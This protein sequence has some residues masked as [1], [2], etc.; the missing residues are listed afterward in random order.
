MTN[1]LSQFQSKRILIVGDI[2][3]DH[4]LFGSTTRVSPEAPVPVVRLTSEK[5]CLGGAANVAYNCAQ[6]GSKVELLG[7][8]GA[9]DST[10]PSMLEAQNIQVHFAHPNHFKTIRKTRILSRHQQLLRLDEEPETAPLDVDTLFE[11]YQER[12]KHADAVI[13]SDYAKGVLHQPTRWIK[14]AQAEKVPVFVD[15]KHHDM[16][17]YRGA[18]AI[19]PNQN[20]L[21]NMLPTATDLNSTI[22]LSQQAMKTNQIENIV[23]TRG[24]AGMMLIQPNDSSLQLKAQTHDVFDVTGAGDTVIAMVALAYCCGLNWSDT[25]TLANLAAS[26]VINKMGTAAPDMNM[27]YHA[28][29]PQTNKGEID[30]HVNQ[31]TAKAYIALA[32]SKGE[33]V[34][35]TNGCFDI[36]HPGHLHYL[37]EAK[38]LGHHLVVALNTDDSVRRIK[39]NNRP[40]NPLK[41]RATMLLALAAVDIV[42]SFNEDTPEA[43][44]KYLQPDVLVKGGDYP[45]ETIAGADTVLASGGQVKQLSFLDG[46]STTD[47]IQRIQTEKDTI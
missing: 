31:A 26:Q 2:I 20:E 1:I 16:S 28:F 29:V 46:Y 25:L 8:I 43:L 24:A 44:I 30:A 34:V 21:N 32:Q 22:E 45:I 39:S 33:R 37:R 40:I 10:I 13:L 35:L 18:T 42:V 12:L 4:Y 7:C 27:L 5:H 19:T 9:D 14:A 17:L 36:L 11:H 23:L 38:A 15:P 3:L 6:M 41:T 47:F